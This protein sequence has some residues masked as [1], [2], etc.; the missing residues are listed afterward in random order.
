GSSL[1]GGVWGKGGRMRSLCL[2]VAV[3]AM[4]LSA[5]SQADPITG[6]WRFKDGFSA[7]FE[8]GGGLLGKSVDGQDWTGTWHRDGEQVKIEAPTSVP[9]GLHKTYQISKLNAEE[10]LLKAVESGEF[11]NAERDHTP[12]K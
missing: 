7:T 11:L 1:C 6:S 2:I 4:L 9:I 10:L 12:T 5:C 8:R 3:A